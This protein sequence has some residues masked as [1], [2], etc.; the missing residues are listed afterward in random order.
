MPRAKD[1][2]GAQ[3]YRNRITVHAL[4]D[5]FYLYNLR[6]TFCTDLQAAGSG[7]FSLPGAN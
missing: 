2:V 4:A 5:D 7:Y 1:R 3:L 6:H